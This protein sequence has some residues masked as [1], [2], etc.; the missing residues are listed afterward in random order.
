MEPWQC[1]VAGVLRVPGVA[2]LCPGEEAARLRPGT[3][4]ALESHQHAMGSAGPDQPP[5]VPQ[6]DVRGLPLPCTV[7]GLCRVGRVDFSGVF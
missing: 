7:S 6:A 4:A 1:P 5:R 2:S 3:R